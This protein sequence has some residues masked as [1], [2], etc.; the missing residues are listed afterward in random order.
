MRKYANNLC[1][2]KT[3]P[4]NRWKFCTCGK[5][6]LLWKISPDRQI[7]F[8]NSNQTQLYSMYCKTQEKIAYKIMAKHLS[9]VLTQLKYSRHFFSSETKTKLSTFQTTQEYIGNIRNSFFIPDEKNATRIVSF[10]SESWLR[11]SKAE[12][13][14]TVRKIDH[15]YTVGQKKGLWRTCKNTSSRHVTD[16]LLIFEHKQPVCARPQDGYLFSTP[17]IWNDDRY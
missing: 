1:Q 9:C 17:I 16:M 7:C 8:W 14:W 5:E 4:E 10:G 13:A 2:S 6:S 15:G 12:I 11:V 3:A